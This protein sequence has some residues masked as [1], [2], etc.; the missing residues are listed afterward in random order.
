MKVNRILPII[1]SSSIAVFAQAGGNPQRSKS[2]PQDDVVRITTSIVQ[3]DVVVTDKNDQMISDLKLEDFKVFDNG[4]KQD[5][6]FIEFAGVGNEPR[7]EGS[8]SVAGQP[9]EPE[10]SRNVTSKDLR[11][12]F[13]FVIDDLTIPF[14]DV[15]KVRNLLTNFVDNQ[16]TDGD[17]VQIVR[18]VGGNG[19]LQQFTSDKRILRRAIAQITPQLHGYSAFNN[20]SAPE[21][22]SANLA[23]AQAI[24]N[25]G[26]SLTEAAVKASNA[27][28]DE[29]GVTKG[30]RMLSTLT[31]T[32]DVINNMK[33]LPG[34]K[35]LVLLSGGLPLFETAQNQ[36]ASVGG[37]PVS[38][39][40]GRSYLGNVTFMLRQLTDR[41]S[42]AGVVINT[43]DVRGMK[44]NRGVSSFADPGNE[45]TSALFGG[46]S[47]GRGFGRIPNMAEFDNLSLDTFAG[48]FGLQILSDTTGGVSVVNTDNFNDGLERVMSRSSYYLLAYKPT[49]PFDGKFHKLEVKVTR[50]GARVYTRQGYVATADAPVK[51]LTKEQTIIRAA[52]S[53][54]AKREVNVAGA[55][56]YRFD[57]ANRAAIDIN[58]LI[59]AKDLEFQRDDQGHQATTFDVVAFVVNNMGKSENGFSQTVNLAL[60]PEE[61]QRALV[62]GITYTGTANLAPGA[63]QL[64][65]VIREP[66]SGKLGTVSQ[67]LEVPDLSKKKL[68]MSS[69]FLFSVDPSNGT[70]G[71]PVPLTALRR[72]PRN[73]D[74]RFAALVY[75]PKIESGNP[76]VRCEVIISRDNRVLLQEPEQ[77]L[78]GSAQSGRMA[79][80]GQYSLAKASP[81]RYVLTLVITDPLADKKERTLVRSIDFD[82]VD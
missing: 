1:M 81:G 62:N 48:H 51:N 56:L 66:S 67:Y 35:N 52:M 6:Q 26:A 75:N 17:L 58:L 32:S 45:A 69:I 72:L 20:L 37:A 39:S 10:I 27:I 63:Y 15:L 36:S 50:P 70:S 28:I 57:D 7:V 79:K 30:L 22:L 59:D 24:T 12:V 44:A 40:E 76:Q 68:T 3:T 31:I 42:R 74:L 29:D 16:M 43:M 82:L 14:E 13:A 77:P 60:S 19:F 38:I 46:A 78:S 41:A 53:P 11:R 64:R 2:E 61:Y 21:R 18:V 71:T 80:I 47:G 4:K 5:L 9:V 34:R 65:A 33:S 73:L 55:I 25:D 8:L 49:E 23:L 54:L